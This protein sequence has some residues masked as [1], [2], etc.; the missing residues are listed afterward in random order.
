M[1]GIGY[2]GEPK[3]LQCEADK[4]TYCIYLEPTYLEVPESQ[5]CVILN[6]QQEAQD[7]GDHVIMKSPA[8]YYVVHYTG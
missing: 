3:T 1:A 2:T 7:C 8:D 5:G 6:M 4:Q